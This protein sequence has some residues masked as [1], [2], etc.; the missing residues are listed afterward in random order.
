M[1]SIRVSPDRYLRDGSVA[2]AGT[3]RGSSGYRTAPTFGAAA[4]VA[5]QSTT[6]DNGPHMAVDGNAPRPL[7]LPGGSTG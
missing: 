7:D 1:R 2:G 5:K 3:G 4:T 6:W